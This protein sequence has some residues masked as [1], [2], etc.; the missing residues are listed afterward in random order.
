MSQEKEE[1]RLRALG[2]ARMKR[3][4]E[5]R[6]R[7]VLFGSKTFACM[8][9]CGC[10]SACDDPMCGCVHDSPTAARPPTNY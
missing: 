5:E 3:E 9:V 4:A 1:A 7:Q 10:N 8:N 2:L 6:A